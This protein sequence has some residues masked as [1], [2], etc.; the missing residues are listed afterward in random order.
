MRGQS[1]GWPGSVTE[2]VARFALEEARIPTEVRTLATD[3]LVDGIG[4]MLAGATEESGTLLRA[5][6]NDLAG[7][8]EATVVATTLRAPATLAA[9]AN[10]V[11]G[12]ALD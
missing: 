3:H 4:V 9:W 11:A 12:H 10:G 7:S 6:L 8:P 1:G 5:H 2:E